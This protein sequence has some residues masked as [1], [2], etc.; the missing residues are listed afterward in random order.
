MTDDLI[1][2][3][4]DAE[5]KMKFL[6]ASMSMLIGIPV[7]LAAERMCF[8]Q[9]TSGDF[10][11]S[12]ANG[13]VIEVAESDHANFAA[14][15]CAIN[16]WSY[17]EG[18]VKNSA[19]KLITQATC[20]A[21]A[22][23][24]NLR[25][26]YA[27]LGV[28]FRGTKSNLQ[29][30]KIA[31]YHWDVYGPTSTASTASSLVVSYDSF[32][33]GH[34]FEVP[35][36]YTITLSIT[37]EDGSISKATTT[38]DV[39]ARDKVTY[40]VDS[41]LGDDR[42][43]GKSMQP[44]LTCNVDTS[45]VGKCNGPWKTA[46]RSFAELG[47]P[48]VVNT[49]P[50]GKYTAPATCSSWVD[51]KATLYNAGWFNVYRSN[52]FVDAM[53]LKD[54][55]GKYIGKEIPLRVCNGYVKTRDSL[56]NPGDQVLFKRG[57]TFDLETG[58][59]SLAKYTA[60]DAT[61]TYKYEKMDCNSLL[62]VPHWPK[63]KGVNYGAYGVGDKPLIQNVGE[64]S[65]IALQYQGVGELNT[66][67]VDLKFDLESTS[68]NASPLLGNRASLFFAPGDP[69]NTVFLRTEL[70]KFNQ[71]IIFQGSVHG[72][73]LKDTKSYDSTIVHFFTANS[74]KD[75]ALVGNNMDL[76]GNH[77]AYSSVANGFIYNNVFSRPAFGRTA[78]RLDGGLYA[79]PNRFVWMAKNQFIGWIDNRDSS[80][81]LIAG[82]CAYGDGKRYNYMLVDLGP[83]VVGS[84]GT[85]D[86]VFTKNLVKDAETLM[87]LGND[88]NV[89]IYDNVFS[90]VDTTS[91]SRIIFGKDLSNRPLKNINFKNNVVADLGSTVTTGGQ[92]I[93]DVLNYYQG[94]CSDQFDHKAI[95]ILNNT[96]Y[97]NNDRKVL[98]YNLAQGNDINGVKLPDLSF[99]E[100]IAAIQGGL[101]SFSGNTIYASPTT[102][103]NNALVSKRRFVLGSGTSGYVP[104][105]NVAESVVVEGKDTLAQS[106]RYYGA[107][108]YMDMGV[109]AG[110]AFMDKN[111]FDINALMANKLK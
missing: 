38:V 93:F 1:G 14:R 47:K 80:T 92:A 9:E 67:F 29:K 41:A 71:G 70:Q 69:V 77:L 61:T 90:T 7:A 68:K 84:I 85:R 108:G 54:A 34:V 17:Y 15:K 35:G 81:C 31:T 99:N 32:N 101:L 51:V 8:N 76:S 60:S 82:R 12:A 91:S 50:G 62:Q 79:D 33:M 49:Y 105:R 58:L 65:C 21:N 18:K 10:P 6:I 89:A 25:K 56:L 36:T 103:V 59:N 28:F 96:I 109:S 78:W 74:A 106:Y 27:P 83:N 64:A 19:G 88:E 40:Y 13:A 52:L 23:E 55:S 16:Y 110:N 102:N 63:A 39:W 5:M 30:T 26:G 44:D 97:V 87:G 22:S 43:S 86:V 94:K 75:V 100:G 45:A 37:G 53:A 11:S 107:K 66:S 104:D 98:R 46:T 95:N 57:Q 48:Y 3:Y 20:A 2:I 72:V 73:F 42:Y 111:G 24:I 4:E